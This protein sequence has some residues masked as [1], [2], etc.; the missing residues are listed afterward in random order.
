MLS[1][2]LQD[3]EFVPC[4]SVPAAD[5]GFRYGMSLFESFRV[6]DGR[7]VFLGEHLGRLRE[8][9][10]QVGFGF[11]I[12]AEAVL[13]ALRTPRISG[14]ARLYVTAGEGGVADP[15]TDPA[16]FLFAE[17]RPPIPEEKRAAGYA[18]AI[19][20]ERRH[21]LLGGLKTANYWGNLV[22]LSR[23]LRRG[24]DEAVLFNQ[25]GNVLSASM[26]NLFIVRHGRVETPPVSSGARA[27]IVRAWVSSRLVVE[28][29]LLT[30]GDLIEAEEIFL[31]SSWLGILSA[32][33]LEDRLLPSRQTARDLHLEY[34]RSIPAL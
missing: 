21:P 30:P 4:G 32:N 22:A 8:S 18:L 25:E 34:G 6:V 17:E 33:S 5:R 20:P 14:M 13:N 7:A 10:V 24:K 2:R 28:E 29:R 15:V 26:A 1:W 9:C 19:D 12:R 3:R 16:V 31:T 27:G 11:D 23:A